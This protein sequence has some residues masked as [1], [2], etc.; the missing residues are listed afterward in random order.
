[1]GG[2]TKNDGMLTFDEDKIC[3]IESLKYLF[4]ATQ[5]GSGD[6]SLSNVRNLK[7]CNGIVIKT[8]PDEY[9]AVEYIENN[10]WAYTIINYTPQQY[11]EFHVKYMIY[12]NTATSCIFCAGAGSYQLVLLCTSG[13]VVD[14]WLRYFSTNAPR[15]NTQVPVNTWITI[16]INKDGIINSNN[17]TYQCEYVSAL[18]GNN[19]N[20][21]IFRRNTNDNTFKGKISEFY[22]KRN[23]RYQIYL[24]PCYRKSDN[25]VGFYDLISNTFYTN[26]SSEQYHFTAGNTVNSPFLIMKTDILNNGEEGVINWNNDIGYIYGGYIDIINGTLVKTH[27]IIHPTSVWENT[28]ETDVVSIGFYIDD[29]LPVKATD[30]VSNVVYSSFWITSTIL[31]KGMVVYKN[32]A[33]NRPY[34]CIVGDRSIYPTW[35]DL[36]DAVINSDSR[37]VYPLNTPITYNL[38]PFPLQSIIGKNTFLYDNNDNIDIIYKQDNAINISNIH[39]NVLLNSDINKLQNEY[40]RVEYIIGVGTGSVIDTGINGNNDNLR[41]V[42]CV[43]INEVRSYFGFFGNYVGESYDCWRLITMAISTPNGFYFT[44]NRKASSSP[45]LYAMGTSDYTEKKLYFDISIE[46]ASSATDTDVYERFEE[47]SAHGTV[48]NTN[49]AI[50]N[51]SVA[52]GGSG[53]A[54][55]KWHYFRIYDSGKLIRNY[56]PCYRKSDNKVGFYDTINHTFNPSIGNTDFILPN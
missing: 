42:F 14:Y 32:V 6:P 9:Q 33:N 29:A 56:I 8:L 53:T 23:G 13:S 51:N 5:D 34:I 36:R 40:K 38:N 55:T 26:Q 49:I 20:L 24:I 52:T 17:I 30:I 27:N 54:R 18:D 46:K 16:D 47:T 43:E 22:I 44:R 45:G 3:N 35:Q 39:R 19:T 41:F 7:G 50:G 31:E 11:D 37:F 28:Y 4:S 1:M 2:I 25:E 15:V 21:Y 12:E 10:G 48:N